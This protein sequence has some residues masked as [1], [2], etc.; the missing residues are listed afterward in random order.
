MNSRQKHLTRAKKGKND[1]FYTQWSDIEK[2]V[3]AYIEYNP[4]V[5]RDKTI[6]LPA[7]DPFES[8]FFKFFATKFN[9][10]GLKKLIATSYAP[11]PIVNTQLSLLP[12]LV[13]EQEI[14]HTRN[15]QITEAYKIELTEIIDENGTGTI[16]IDDVITRLLKE[17][18]IIDSG[19]TS[20]I[21]S[22]L[23]GDSNPDGI[24]NFSAGDFRSQE[25]VN[26]RDEADIIITNP[27]FSLFREFLDW[28]NPNEKQ[29]LI[30]GNM[31][32]ITY[33]EVFPLI[34]DNKI[35][36]GT[37]MGRWISGFIVPD[38]YELYGTEARIEKG[39][40]I[41]STNNALWMTNLDHGKRHQPLSLM[42]MAD[43]IKYSKHKNVKGHKYEKY[44]NYDAL[45][46]P[47]TDSIPSD[48]EELM[49]V[50]I[51]FLDKYNPDQFQIIGASDNGAIDEQYK[52]PHF[53]KHNEPYI[54]G[55][56]VY[57]RI[58]IRVVKR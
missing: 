20:N 33:K 40:R 21:L 35:W 5:F 45:E 18:E 48:Y 15:K 19:G 10:Y 4:N 2:E 43:N 26:L 12:E 27:P 22:Y 14:K 6:L 16:N 28:I 3:N 30:I 42:T 52:L 32:A 47:Y 55:K 17:K 11:S 41:V 9:E 58:F 46:V 37:G 23:K 31:N 53:K 50:P 57:K 25:V 38:S 7:D 29:F 44:D 8:N 54:D 13:P 39:Q 51:S 36:L 24:E 34:K 49:G 1:E 56:K